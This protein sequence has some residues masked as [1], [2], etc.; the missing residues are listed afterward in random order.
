MSRP[1]V[2][3]VVAGFP[4]SQDCVSLMKGFYD[5]G[6][7]AIEVQI[8]FSDPIADGETIMSANDRAIAQ[9]MTTRESFELVKKARSQ[10]VKCKIY[11]M[12]Y[13]QKI[14]HFGYK[15]FADLAKQAQVNGFIVPDLPVDTEEYRKL[16][17]AASEVGIDIIPVLSPGM[18]SDRLSMILDTNPPTV[19]LTSRSGITGTTY[20]AASNLKDVSMEVKNKAQSQIIIGFGIADEADVDNALEYGDMAVVGSA[21]VRAVNSGGITQALELVARLAGISAKEVNV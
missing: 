15:D 14:N 7:S 18:S 19:Y 3:H 1:L 9:G 8:P 10:G 4:S 5:A 12:S 16:E 13:L 21:I 11:I 2:C 6:V 20:N 17:T